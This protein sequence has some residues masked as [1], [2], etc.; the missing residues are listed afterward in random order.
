MARGP[1]IM[2]LT[3]A[4]AVS[5]WGV[6]AACT[7]TQTGS[8]TDASQLFGRNC[9]RCHGPS[10]EG[11][12]GPRIIGPGHNLAKFRN[13]QLLFEFIKSS[14]PQDA[15]GSLKSEEYYQLTVYILR[16]NGYLKAEE[17]PPPERLAEISLD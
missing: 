15:P 2:L 7:G 13:G 8:T 14:M 4:F 17:T 16:A 9:A 3:M 12:I 11:G 10:G 1:R 6:L 5:V